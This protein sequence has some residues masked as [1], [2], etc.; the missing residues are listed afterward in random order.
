[1]S[2]RLLA[3]TGV[4]AV[5]WLAAVP[6]AAWAQSANPKPKLCELLPNNLPLQASGGGRPPTT[7]LG[8]L[9]NILGAQGCPMPACNANIGASGGERAPDYIRLFIKQYKASSEASGLVSQPNSTAYGDS[10]RV[11]Q[12]GNYQSIEFVARSTY[13]VMINAQGRY[14]SVVPDIARHIAEGLRQYPTECLPEGPGSPSSTAATGTPAPNVPVSRPPGDNPVTPNDPANRVTPN[15]IPVAS[16]AGNWS[17]NDGAQVTVSHVAG[18][19]LTIQA[20]YPNGFTAR[21]VGRWN[22]STFVGQYENQDASGVVRG[23]GQ[24]TLYLREGRLE[25]P[26]VSSDGRTGGWSITRN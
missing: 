19:T 8:L 24:Q 7:N 26:W 14:A 17:T 21:M 5:V 9:T 16:L 25:G 6:V 15:Q 3:S 22:G 1:M 13:F 18:D 11:F 20:R 12:T 23:R 4:V 2:T 10:A